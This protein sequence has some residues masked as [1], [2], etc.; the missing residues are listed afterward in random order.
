VAICAKKFIVI[1]DE[2][3]ENVRFRWIET[4]FLC[5]RKWSKKLGEKWEKGIPIEVLPIAYKI[6]KKEIEKQLG[7]EAVVREG[8]EKL[9]GCSLLNFWER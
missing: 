6:T 5:N 9:V 7:G 8:T 4:L 2:K 3:Y 1:A